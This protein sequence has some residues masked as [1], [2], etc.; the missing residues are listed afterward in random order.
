MPRAFV[1][2]DGGGAPFDFRHAKVQPYL[3]NRFSGCHG[4]ETKARLACDAA[5]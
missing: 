2:K 3:V 1:A 4:L 5:P